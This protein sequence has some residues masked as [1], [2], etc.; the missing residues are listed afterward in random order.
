MKKIT[1]LLLVLA[2]AVSVFAGCGAGTNE[3]TTPATDAPTVP[4]TDAPTEAETQA[5]TETAVPTEGETVAPTEPRLS[6]LASLIEQIYAEKPVELM[7]GTRDLDLTDTSEDGLMTLK[8]NT[9]L[10]S[11]EGIVEAAV[12]EAM[13]GAQAYSL[14]LVRVADPANAKTVAEQM[15]VGIDPRKWICVEADDMM[16]SGSGDLVMLIM[17]SSVFAENGLTAQAMTDAFAAV[18]GGELDFT[19]A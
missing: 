3:P 5:P 12:S 19:L 16:V 6:G 18:C 14:V 10:E 15:K 7:V 9:G 8:Y 13:I 17:V 4:V 11:T 2:L 1:A